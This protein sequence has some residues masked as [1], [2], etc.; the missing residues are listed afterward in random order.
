MASRSPS[1]T[2]LWSFANTFYLADITNIRSA[3]TFTFNETEIF[4]FKRN[5]Q[6]ILKSKRKR[7]LEVKKPYLQ[8]CFFLYKKFSLN[9][10]RKVSSNYEVALLIFWVR[11]NKTR[12]KKKLFFISISIPSSCQEKFNRF[13]NLF[14]RF[15]V[16]G[17]SQLWINKHLSWFIITQ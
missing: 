11:V 9:R 13:E 3:F 16:K 14:K 8:F 5:Q 12:G 1:T 2:V 7:N 17:P 10:V 6:S 4:S 15:M